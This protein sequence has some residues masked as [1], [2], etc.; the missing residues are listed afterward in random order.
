MF[1]GVTVNQPSRVGRRATGWSAVCA[2]VWCALAGCASRDGHVREVDPSGGRGVAVSVPAAGP[3]AGLT[4][5]CGGRVTPD[6]QV[7]LPGKVEFEFFKAEF[8]NTPAT[9]TMLQCAAD[10]LTRNPAVTRFRISV[11]MDNTGN[12]DNSMRLS[13]AR[14]EAIVQWLVRHGIQAER[15]SGRGF[16]PSR[17]LFPNDSPEHKAANRRAEFQVEDVGLVALAGASDAFAA[18]PRPEGA[19]AAVSTAV[20]PAP[21]SI[22]SLAARGASP[23]LVSATPQPSAYAV[24][25]G[26][27][28]Y[29]AGLPPPTGAR[30]DAESM[31]NVFHTTFGIASEHLRVLLDDQ[32]TKGAIEGAL[33]WAKSA[34]PAGGRVYFYFSGH[35]SP[36]AES[37]TSYLV[38]AD[39][40][41]RYLEA[42]AIALRDV[43]ASLAATKAREVIAMVD[44]CFSGTGGRSVLPPGARPLV[45]VHEESTPPQIA[46]F[47]ASGANE[48]SGPVPGG[49]GGLFTKYVVDGLGTGAADINGDGQISLN[50]LAEWVK[51]RVAREAKKDNRDQ[52]PSLAVGKGIGSADGFIVEWGLA[53]K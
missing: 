6:G 31:A 21:G 3:L 51:P 25:I 32:A 16:G 7:E 30:A 50:E 29:A 1:G 26:I 44:S 17:P 46:L 38:P 24:V 5:V 27:E 12:A 37:R 41:P 19:A 40:D 35:G 13:Q 48:M 18:S 33:A 53:A 15:L 23:F 52:N 42:T 36:D 11:F 20:R 2:G 49:S 45:R 10:F 47:S 14:A 9:D 39:G 22:P 4:P 43:L 8:R 34:T 28:R